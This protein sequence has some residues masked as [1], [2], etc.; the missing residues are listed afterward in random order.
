MGY[1]RIV[2]G[3]DGSE[4]AGRAVDRAARLSKDLGSTLILVTA[5]APIG[6]IDTVAEEIA[7]AARDRVRAKG[8]E[9]EA[10]VQEGDP[11][12][13]LTAVA[14]AEDAGLVVVG[15]QGLG[16]ARRVRLGGVAERVAVMAPCDVLIVETQNPREEPAEGPLYRRLL[17]GTDGSPT[18][19]AAVQR[20]YDFGMM[21]GVG[22]LV[23]TV[24]DDDVLAAIHLE[25]ARRIK[26]R[27]LGVEAKVLRGEPA[28]ALVKEADREGC[29]LIVVGNRG[30]TGARRVLLGSIPSRV[31]HRADRDVLIARTVGR[32]I[33]DLRPGQGAVVDAGSGKMVAAFLGEDGGVLA[34]DPRCTHMG[35][36]VRFNQSERTWD[37]PCHGSRYD[38]EG[39]VLQGPAKKPLPRTTL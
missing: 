9:A 33:K 8:I 23:A 3:T 28:K 37:C 4:T 29:E 32:T 34:L 22:V 36:T 38:L 35:C 30:L 17:V 1:A 25:D 19:T 39:Q 15:D 10:V 7:V 26:P 16:R 21:I 14:A 2:V 13:V 11:A 12:E 24:T 5:S 20:A 18:A 6:M 27:A 31:A